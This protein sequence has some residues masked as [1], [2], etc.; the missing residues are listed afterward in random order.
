MEESKSVMFPKSLHEAWKLYHDGKESSCYISGGTWLR[1]QWEANP[2]GTAKQ[3][4]C[5]DCLPGLQTISTS[6]DDGETM[7]TIGA[8]ATL[9]QCLESPVIGESFSGFI[10]ACRNIAAPAIRNQATVGGNI[11]TAAGDTI[12][13]LLVID[14]QL[15]WFN[16]TDIES[17]PLS[18]WL[19]EREN[20]G[21]NEEERILVSVTIPVKKQEKKGTAF[22]FYTKVGRREAFIPSVVTVAGTGMLTIEGTLADVAL[23]AG[24]G[25]TV[26]GRLPDVEALLHRARFSPELLKKV[27]EKIMT[28]YSP[29]PDPFAG[30][31]YKKT[32]AAN[33]I[34]GE[35][36]RLQEQQSDDKGGVGYAVRS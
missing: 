1:T 2:E 5:V 12:P 17:Q 3:L 35:L 30:V 20:D 4:I 7:V 28:D 10:T 13:S 19:R 32:V 18:D 21:A 15:H 22:S 25:T 24:G 27:H 6:S 36:Y 23:A 8:A 31:Y 16:G 14:A 34:I 11:L 29:P 9:S 26:P 33:V